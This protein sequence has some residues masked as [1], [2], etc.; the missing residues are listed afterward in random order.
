MA[1][2][3]AAVVDKHFEKVSDPRVNRGK[4][5]PLI[6]LMFMALTAKIWGAE[7]CADVEPFANSKRDWFRRFIRLDH[8]V[9]SHDTFGRVFAALDT[10]EFLAAMHAWVDAFAGSLRGQ[11][12]AI[13]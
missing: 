11:G 4:N 1:T 5:Y 7:G 9:P 2:G 3:P 13:D 6:E 8:V 10:A 12:V